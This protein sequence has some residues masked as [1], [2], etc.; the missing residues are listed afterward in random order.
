ML[1]LANVPDGILNIV[2]FGLVIV[3][4]LWGAHMFR[5]GKGEEEI[6]DIFIHDFNKKI[7]L[8]AIL[9]IGSEAI[10]LTII[11]IEH[12][13]D[14]FNAVLR[15]GILL[16]LE[17][18]CTFLFL[19]LSTMLQKYILKRMF[20]DGE[21]NPIEILWIF[22]Y[23]FIIIPLLLVFSF[24]TF[25]FAISYYTSIGAITIV[26]NSIS[27][28]PWEQIRFVTNP[29]ATPIQFGAYILIYFGPF[30]NLLQVVFL[31]ALL[32]T[33][34]IRKLNKD[35][36]EEDEEDEDDEDL[37]ED[38]EEEEDDDDKKKSKKEEALLKEFDDVIEGLHKVLN[39]S[40]AT[41]T[42]NTKNILGLNGINHKTHP[43][44]TD[45]RKT[46][47]V[48]IKELKNLFEGQAKASD[49]QGLLGYWDLMTKVEELGK[50][51]QKCA[52]EIDDKTSDLN[53]A[54]SQTEKDRLNNLIT[55][56]ESEK[57][58]YQDDID[59]NKRKR[60]ELV[61]NIQ[62]HAKDCRLI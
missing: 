5:S 9:A 33:S 52:Q 35:E 44:I 25:G 59:K 14:I 30:I 40:K 15:N 53:I 36:D 12:D 28:L 47:E 20:M 27:P 13:I 7:M 2:S 21:F 18:G 11:A 8:L 26:F 41:I 1:F 46:P 55:S 29:T 17:L 19:R 37:Y 42:E 61:K 32:I 60:E 34:K 45:K 43:S 49:P 23:L 6:A 54:T 24:P 62:Q 3:V 50:A 58:R 38:V 10:G 39:I 57:R 22:P 48:V 31:P 51:K 16:F 4:I 56:L